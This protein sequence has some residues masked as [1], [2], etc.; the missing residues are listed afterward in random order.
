MFDRVGERGCGDTT[1]FDVQTLFGGC[2]EH[3]AE[4]SLFCG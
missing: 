4:I 1:M 2:F 3:V